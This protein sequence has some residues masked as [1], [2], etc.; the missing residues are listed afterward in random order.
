[1]E[2]YNNSNRYEKPRP[3]R[4]SALLNILSV[5][6]QGIGDQVYNYDCFKRFDKV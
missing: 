4:V 3:P 1:M 5:T 6:F 2:V